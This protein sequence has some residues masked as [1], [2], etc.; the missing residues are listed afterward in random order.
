MSITTLP[1]RICPFGQSPRLRMRGRNAE[2]EMRAS[3][4][5]LRVRPRCDALFCRLSMSTKLLL[6][7]SPMQTLICTIKFDD[8]KDRSGEGFR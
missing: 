1:I 4:N 2:C 6:H 5:L 3:G 7:F 8:R